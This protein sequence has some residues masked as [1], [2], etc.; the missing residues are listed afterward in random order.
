ME[1]QHELGRRDGRFVLKRPSDT[2]N[3]LPFQLVGA[4]CDFYQYAVDRPFGFPVFQWIQTVSG[5]GELEVGGRSVE[6]PPGSAMLLYPEEP[7]AYRP[8]QADWHVNWMS[9]SGYAVEGMLQY[10]GLHASSVCY[11]AEPSATDAQ[12][13]RAL[14]SLDSTSMHAGID[15][16][17]IVYLFILE[18]LK[19]AGPDT[20]PE[21]RSSA[22]RLQP[23]LDFIERELARP[24]GLEELAATIGVTPQYFCDLFRAVTAYRPTEFINRRRIEHAKE[25]LV[26]APQSSIRQI[27]RDVGFESESYFSTVFRRHEGV[28]PREYRRRNAA[29]QETPTAASSAG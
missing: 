29:L 5:S 4:G 6:V 1:N 24:I 9:F 16:S 19:Y 18:I 10:S 14:R 23:A 12:I 8:T 20:G 15:G 13:R 25:L 7:H 2:A 28:P 17:G 11:L 27:G 22:R 21:A 26:A 3:E